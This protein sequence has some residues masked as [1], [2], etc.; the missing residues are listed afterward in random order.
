[1][2]D[3]KKSGQNKNAPKDRTEQAKLGTSL[4]DFLRPLSGDSARSRSAPDPVASALEA[5]QRLAL[6]TDLQNADSLIESSSFSCSACGGLNPPEN[7]FCAACGISLKPAPGRTTAD[8]RSLQARTER[9]SG[10]E[11]PV[12][13]PPGPHQYHHHYHH[14]YFSYGEAQGPGAAMDFRPPNSAVPREAL[15]ARPVAGAPLSRAEVA[16][17]KVSQDWASACNTKHLDDLV[18][19]YAPDATVLRPNVPAVRGTAA[20]REFFV[21]VLDAGLGEVEMEPLRTETVGD[22]AYEAGRCQML[23]PIAMSKRREERGKYLM[24]LT[25]QGGDWK[26][27]ADCWSTDMSLGAAAE[28]AQNPSS[29]TS[30]KIV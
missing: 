20:I 30:R 6:E 14:H 18:S 5:M 26:I 13:L 22:V 10:E 25:R 27:L 2:N 29:G 21:S 12:P 28:P 4:E 16:I 19:L 11:P 24:I 7:R 8:P 15:R 1:M 3:E 17:R 9:N 23:V